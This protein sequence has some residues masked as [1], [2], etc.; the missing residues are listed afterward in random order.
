M[1]VVESKPV[2]SVVNSKPKMGQLERKEFSKLEKDIQK[3]E[4]EIKVWDDKLSDPHNT[5]LGYS[6]LAEFSKEIEQLRNKL[7]V[8]ELRWLELSEAYDS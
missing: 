4:K 7:E 6:A 1:Q 5:S 2:S 3:L 8:K